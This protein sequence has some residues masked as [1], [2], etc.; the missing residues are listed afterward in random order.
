M[1]N[2]IERFVITNINKGKTDMEFFKFV[3]EDNLETSELWKFIQKTA[4]I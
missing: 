4:Q 1:E 2:L 3:G